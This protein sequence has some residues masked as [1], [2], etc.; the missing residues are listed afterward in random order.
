M[1]KPTRYI[2]VRLTEL[3]LNVLWSAIVAGE[4]EA[5]QAISDDLTLSN[6]EA[7]IQYAALKRGV[8]KFRTAKPRRR[9]A[10]KVG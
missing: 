8:E 1:S 10:K 5:S 6:R 4:T 2:N 3:E 7:A 9:A